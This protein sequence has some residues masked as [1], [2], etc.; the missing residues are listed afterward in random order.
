MAHSS[1]PQIHYS[2]S[3]DKCYLH[4]AYHF[5][6]KHLLFADH[7]G[8]IGEPTQHTRV[9]EVEAFTFTFIMVHITTSIHDGPHFSFKINFVN[10]L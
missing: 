4:T 5:V 10:R 8:V 6:S 3:D 1:S 9:M 7:Y 2:H